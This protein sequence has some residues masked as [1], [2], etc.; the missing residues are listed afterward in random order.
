MRRRGA[1][2][3]GAKTGS[4][5]ELRA[6]AP[7]APPD[8]DR[9]ASRRVDRCPGIEPFTGASIGGSRL[10]PHRR[11]TS[12]AWPTGQTSV[13]AWGAPILT[14]LIC[15]E[16]ARRSRADGSER[17]GQSARWMTG[18]GADARSDSADSS[19]R[20]N[21]ARAALAVIRSMQIGRG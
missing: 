17:S 6:S 7:H 11:P 19:V 4:L 1:A 14:T 13:P 18:G 3:D 5:R 15:A 9:L 10:I 16:S 20:R 21:A 2:R 8:I 12:L